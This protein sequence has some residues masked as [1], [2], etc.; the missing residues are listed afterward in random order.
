MRTKSNL[1]TQLAKEQRCAASPTPRAKAF[2]EGR[3][4]TLA[5]Q[6]AKFEEKNKKSDA[7]IPYR[8]SQPWRSGE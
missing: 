5:V 1:S 4:A 8:D 3:Y 2:A 6:V 7:S